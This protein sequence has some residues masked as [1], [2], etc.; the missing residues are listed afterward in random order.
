MNKIMKSKYWLLGLIGVVQ[1][2]YSQS[3][4]SVTTGNVPLATYFRDVTQGNLSWIAKQFNIGIAEASLKA[5]RVYSDPELNL[6]YSNNQDKMMHLGQAYEAGVSYSFNL[7]NPRSARIHLAQSEL[8]LANLAL[9]AFFQNLRADAALIFYAG[10][11]E[12]LILQVQEDNYQ[13][14]RD[15]ARADSIRF[16]NGVIMEADA[17]QSALEARLQNNE[18]IRAHSAWHEALIRMS[19]FRGT[20]GSD[21]LYQPMGS[22]EFPVREFSL[23]WLLGQAL[24]NRYDLQIAIQMRTI[25][26]HMIRLVKANRAI[27]LDI[28][29][30]LSYSTI[31]T[32][33]I[34]PSPAHIGYGIGISLPLKF[35]SM[36]KSELKASQLALKQSEIDCR[37]AENILTT[38][39]RQ[40]FVIYE[41]QKKQLNQYHSGLLTEAESILEKKM[42]SYQR[43]ETSFLDVL[44]AQRTYN[45][46]RKGFYEAHYDYLVALIELE[47][48]TGIWDLN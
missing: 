2:V 36:N 33:E 38:S 8:D 37:D 41:A 16:R 44:H 32:N 15:L 11:K 17:M 30:G 24:N 20:D 47:R 4:N 19:R 34:A 25:S 5:A 35:S 10:L 45:E 48:A 9:Q 40:A 14:M 21:T 27:E 43:G 39:V 7:G 42:Y 6:G 3:P 23:E 1:M 26:E 22:L 31:A 12:Q 28:E 46:I 18:L 29:T 13:R